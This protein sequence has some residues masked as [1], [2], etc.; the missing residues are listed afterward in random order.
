MD[1]HDAKIR[2]VIIDDEKE[3]VKTIKEFLE[4][5]GFTVIFAFGGKRGLEVIKKEKPDLVILD[6]AMPDMDGRDVLINLKKDEETKDI[7][8]LLLSGRGGQFDEE[9]GMEL[10]AEQYVAKPY[11]GEALLE[12]IKKVLSGKKKDVPGPPG[13][14]K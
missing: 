4:E 1:G 13:E 9:Y 7:P 10:G 2:V 3:L 14:E 8:V 11:R 6:I 12:Q 5:R